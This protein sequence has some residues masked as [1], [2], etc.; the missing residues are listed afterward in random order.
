MLGAFLQDAGNIYS[1]VNEIWDFLPLIIIMTIAI[2]M[3]L[4][5]YM[6][7]SSFRDKAKQKIIQQ[8]CDKLNLDYN[9]DALSFPVKSFAKAGLLPFYEENK[10]KI[11]NNLMGKIDNISFSVAEASLNEIRGS[12]PQNQSTASTFRGLLVRLEFPV[13]REATVLLSKKRKPRFPFDSPQ[14]NPV[15]FDKYGIEQVYNV[16]VDDP[17][18]TAEIL[19]AELAKAI[20]NLNSQLVA[21]SRT[22]KGIEEAFGKNI[23]I[24]IPTQK[25]LFEFSAFKSVTDPKPLENMLFMLK[26]IEDIINELNFIFI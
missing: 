26:I 1:T 19:D 13:S 24:V 20:L 9:E 17:D 25:S 6:H 15:S 4:I 14:L 22:A 12:D 23:L 2:V 8:I 3:F 11:K 7:L 10:S 21:D 18:K 5:P 16:Y